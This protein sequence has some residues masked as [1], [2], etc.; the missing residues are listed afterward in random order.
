MV[1]L[2]VGVPSVFRAELYSTGTQ[3]DSTMWLFSAQSAQR[4]AISPGHQSLAFWEEPVH[5]G[6]FCFRCTHAVDE[7]KQPFALMP[8]S[9]WSCSDDSLRGP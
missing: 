8:G 6:S 2:V 1:L 3:T 4:A 7:A 5:S 9:L